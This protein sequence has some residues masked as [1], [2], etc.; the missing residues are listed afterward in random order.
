MNTP[1]EENTPTGSNTP[2]EPASAVTKV[3]ALVVPAIAVLHSAAL[4]NL[5]AYL[6]PEM[7]LGTAACLLFLGGTWKGQRGLWTGVALAG[8][9]LAGATLTAVRVMWIYR[10]TAALCCDISGLVRSA[11]TISANRLVDPI[12]RLRP[13]PHWTR[14]L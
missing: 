4:A 1:P 7:V 3:L 14:A 12:G 13:R 10:I 9:L 11:A 5:F 6:V 2:T 8:L